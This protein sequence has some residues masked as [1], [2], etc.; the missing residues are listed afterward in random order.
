MSKLPRQ[1]VVFIAVGLGVSV[2]L[3]VDGS[4]KEGSIG[5]LIALSGAV[6]LLS[7]LALIVAVIVRSRRR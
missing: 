6:G 5:L 4:R 1:F 7:F 3:I 2:F